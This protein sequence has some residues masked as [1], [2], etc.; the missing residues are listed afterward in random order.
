MCRTKDYIFGDALHC[1]VIKFGHVLDLHIANSLLHMYA[2][3]GLF[4][5]EVL[6]LFD[7]MPERDVV[8]W[9]VIID[10]LSKNGCFDEVLDAF[11][12]MCRYGVQP[13]SVTLLVLVSSCLKIGDFGLGKLIH[14]YIIKRG[15]DMSENLGNGLIDIYIYIY[16]LSLEIWS[17]LRSCLM[18]FS[19]T[20]L[21]DG[22]MQN[23]EL[24]RASSIFDKMPNKDTTAWNVMLNGYSEVGDM[25]S[26]ETIF[27]AMPDRDLVSWNTMIVGYTQNKKYMKSLE[28]LTE[29]LGFGLKPDR[30]TLVRLFSMCGYA[31]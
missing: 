5:N 25:S 27:R 14:L 18:V 24:E 11:N 30:L 23:G 19:W 2:S 1:S 16:M 20:S 4:S 10:D 15:I 3:F 13:N 26:A 12:E 17:R 7:E 31:G 6:N 22:F 21:L 28:M 29:M 9:N 8:S